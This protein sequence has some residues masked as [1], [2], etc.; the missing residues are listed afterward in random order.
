MSKFTKYLMRAADCAKPEKEAG[1]VSAVTKEGFFMTK[2]VGHPA[3]AA[4]TVLHAA[5]I[6]VAVKEFVSYI[7]DEYNK[8]LNNELPNESKDSE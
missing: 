5:E 2:I 1:F 6:D 7:C 3:A 8:Q 4:Q